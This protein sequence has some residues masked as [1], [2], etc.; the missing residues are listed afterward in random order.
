MFLFFYGS[1]MRGGEN[2][3]LLAGQR[4]VAEVT[5]DPFY[6]IIDLRHY[7]GLV[8]DETGGF[9]IH[10]ELWSVDD[11]CLSELDEFECEETAFARRP[12]KITGHSGVEAYFWAGEGASTT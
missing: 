4:F 2:N 8:P 11:K 6:R 12:I 7:T 5:T 1:L 10:G 9:A 3:H